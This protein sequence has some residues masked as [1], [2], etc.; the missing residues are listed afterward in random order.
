[1]AVVNKAFKFCICPNAA[2]AALINKTVG[3]ARFVYNYFLDMR[4]RTYQDNGKGLNHNACSALLTQLKRDKDHLW[5][6]EVDKFALQNS[7]RDLN[8]AYNNFFRERAKGNTKQGFPKFKSKHRSKQKYRTNLTNNNIQVDMDA[9][10]I[11]L[12]K[13]GWIKFRKNKRM[14]HLPGSIVNVTVT[15]ASSGKYFVAVL[16]QVEIN[17]LPVV[18][19]KVGYDLGLETFAVS[20]NGDFI[21]NPRYLQREL[22]K[23]AILQKQLSRKIRGSHNYVKQHI[24]VARHHEY[25]VNMRQ[26]FLHQLSTQIIREN[27]VICLENLGVK[28][29]VKNKRLAK[30]ISDAGW[31]LFRQMVSYKAKWYGRTLVIIDRFF[32]S[33]K[34]CNMCGETNPMLTLSIRNWQCPKCQTVHNRD[35][36]AAKNI[37]AEGLRLLSI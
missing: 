10:K 29:M 12:P 13:L 37:L 11:K 9:R 24:K 28:N 22:K 31:G 36:N 26:N 27:Q 6:L 2:Q 35:Q 23:L 14:G 32:P 16:C 5:L 21:E 34:K 20:S 25:I 1:M 17:E 4:I 3:C 30:A 19:N 33:S 8:T 15:R 7:L 18:N